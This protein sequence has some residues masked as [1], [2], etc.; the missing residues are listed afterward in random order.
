MVVQEA[1]EL[2]AVCHGRDSKRLIQASTRKDS[3]KLRHHRHQIRPLVTATRS[4]LVSAIAVLLAAA[5]IAQPAQWVEYTG[6][7][8]PGLGKHIVL[9]SG[10][11]EYRSE[12]VLPQFGKILAVRHGFRCT[13]LFAIDPATGLVDPNHG[14]SIP[15]L[16]AL[17]TA[18]LM[19]IFTRFRALPD[20]QMAHV[21]AYLKTGK[22]VIGM[23]TATH[24]FN[25]PEDSKWSHYSN[26]YRGDLE[27]WQDGF[28]RLVLGEKWISHHG[29]HKHE[30]TRG[31]IAP[32]AGESPIL[33]GI[34]DGAIW[35]ST[36][37]YGVRIKM[38]L[39]EVTPLVLGE[40]VLRAGEYDESDLNY[41][42]RPSDMMPAPGRKNDPMMPVAWTKGYQA[43]DG[44]PG[45]AFTTT[46]GSGADLENEAFR[47]LLVNAAYVL[48]G[49]EEALPAE[50][51]AVDIVGEYTPSAYAFRDDAHWDTRAMRVEEHVLAEAVKE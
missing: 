38:L 48:L 20:E 14:T 32:G 7:E 34:E 24:A 49:M 21:D 8:G 40:V 17:D 16:E 22:P 2:V 4:A 33:R 18:D 28:G 47:R 3:H 25:F 43:P 27:A 1:E 37:V 5:G 23:R 11:E 10:D 15:G 42:M 19:V 12:E 13:V 39:E 51:A 45:K 50:G 6:T 41:G 46:M 29:E 30:S 36:D 31:R 44:A 26:G 35:G 9:I